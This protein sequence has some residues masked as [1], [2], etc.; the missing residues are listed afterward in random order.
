MPAQTTGTAASAWAPTLSAVPSPRPR[1]IAESTPRGRLNSS[2]ISSDMMPERNRHLRLLRELGADAGSGE[3]RR[4]EVTPEDP[5]DPVDVLRRKRLV[6]AQ[7]LADRRDL[8]GRAVRAGDQLRDVAR[9]HAQGEEDQHAGDEQPEQEQGQ[10]CQRV[11]DHPLL[12]ASSA[13]LRRSLTLTEGK[14]VRFAADRHDRRS[15]VEPVAGGVLR[16]DARGLREQVGRFGLVGR[17]ERLGVQ[18]LHLGV[19]V[20]E[21]VVRVGPVLEVVRL[22]VQHEA[23]VVV[24]VDVDVVQPGGEVDRVDLERDADLVEVR[25]EDLRDRRGVEARDRQLE[26]EVLDSGLGQQ[27]L[28]APRGRTG[29]RPRGPRSRGPATGSVRTASR[30]KPSAS[31]NASWS[32]A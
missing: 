25:H 10:S 16:D 26:C 20:R 17:G 32:I 24:L 11:A 6:Q 31:T 8:L 1:R 3:Q 22:G 12:L 2:A 7:P 28:G 30:P 9:Q 27:R 13:R 23:Q 29:R 19:V 14:P 18:A 4:A 5:A 15:V 21:V